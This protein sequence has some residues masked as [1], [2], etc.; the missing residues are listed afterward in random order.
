MQQP[1]PSDEELLRDMLEGDEAAFVALYRRPQG[2]RRMRKWLRNA[3]K[4]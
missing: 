4:S 1:G 2:R 3:S